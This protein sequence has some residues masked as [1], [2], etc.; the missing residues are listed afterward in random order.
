MKAIDFF[1]R[2][3]VLFILLFVILMW[4]GQYAL[5]GF[6]EPDEA[7]FVYVA[8]EMA[9]T[10]NWAVPQRHGEAYGHKPPLMF[11]LIN[12]GSA[13]LPS[14]FGERLPNLVGAALALLAVYGIGRRIR[15]AGTGL[16]ACVIVSTAV[17]FWETCGIGQI[18]ALLTGLE[19][20]A[21]YLL[22]SGQSVRRTACA[23]LLMGLAVLA[24]GPVGLII[25][26][27][28]FLAFKWGGKERIGMGVGKWALVFALSLAVPAVWLAF[29]ALGS[30]TDAY[31][32]EILFSQNLSRAA[33][34]YGHVKP[35]WYYLF[36]LPGD[37]MPWTLF[38]PPAAVFL[39][40]TDRMQLRRLC[41]WCLFVVVFFSIPVS[42][43]GVYIMTAFPP[44]ALILACAASS[45]RENRYCRGVAVLFAFLVPA[46]FAAVSM[47]LF[48][49][50]T[51][52]LIEE[53]VSEYAA[54]QLPDFVPFH[55]C[56]LVSLAFSAGVLAGIRKGSWF[57]RFC[58]FVSAVFSLCSW[59]VYPAFN[60]LKEPMEMKEIAQKY[61]P[62]DGRLLLYDI[63]G[64]TLALHAGRTGKRLDT[65]AEMLNAMQIE[66]HGVAVF[67]DK[68]AENLDARFGCLTGDGGTFAM[69]SK[70]YVWKVFDL[71]PEAY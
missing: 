13:V 61:I 1:K 12:A 70:V 59:I 55:M 40:K 29:A 49:P 48:F 35:V 2:H 69:G 18:D 17:Q 21:F 57:V 28:S 39:Y 20:S 46:V 19:L 6:W 68:D 5:R 8:R 14:P 37:F 44:L 24:K 60:E 10:G 58:L 16:L 9:D 63:Y 56:F 27:G 45:I 52:G 15:G 54:V 38:L 7:R 47:V 51:R 36:R 64:E 62:E 71:Q 33:G 34:S 3:P 31:F 41:A 11:W 30:G 66:E 42:K 26:L 4:G 22:V 50:W 67:L 23:S 65:D 43:R 25:P 53:R 32:K